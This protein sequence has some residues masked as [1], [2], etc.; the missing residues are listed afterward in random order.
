MTNK[1]FKVVF[2]MLS[3][4]IISTGI[5]LLLTYTG[6]A[7]RFTDATLKISGNDFWE[8]ETRSPYTFKA[9]L[10]LATIILLSY[11]L[12]YGENFLKNKIR[13][14][15]TLFGRTVKIQINILSKNT[16]PKQLFL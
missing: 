3:S 16:E 2:W 11:Y 5:F 14:I 10:L 4:T 6:L 7:K 8:G 1:V 9:I 13:T 12:R 15:N